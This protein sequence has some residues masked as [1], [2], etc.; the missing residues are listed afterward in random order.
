MGEEVAQEGSLG[1][2]ILAFSFSKAMITSPRTHV[3]LMYLPVLTFI[4]KDIHLT[5]MLGD[6]LRRLKIRVPG[7]WHLGHYQKRAGHRCD[8][9]T[10]TTLT[11][12]GR[13]VL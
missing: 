1:G 3:V 9:Q 12:L 7:D 6:C 8:H 5:C 11:A 2:G 10:P 13:C 4:T